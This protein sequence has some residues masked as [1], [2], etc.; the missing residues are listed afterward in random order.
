MNFPKVAVVTPGSF[1]IPSGRSSSVE[2]VIE[3]MMPYAAAGNLD[4]RI[5]GRTGEDGSLKAMIG[6]VPCLRVPGGA[7]Y[8]PSVLRHLRSW[9][10]DIIDVHNRPLLA[11]RLK[12]KLPQVQV[13]LSLHST[14]FIQGGNFPE[15][16]GR[17]LL[18]QLDGIIVNSGYLRQELFR[19]YPGL[20]VPVY[21]NHLGV[22]LE[23]FVPRWTPVGEALRKARLAEFGWQGRKVV[24]FLGRLI[25]EKGV[26][27]LLKTVPS[28]VREQPEALFLIVG[29]AYY[30]NAKETAYVRGLKELAEAYPDHVAFLPF[31]PYPQVADW[32]N[33]ADVVAVPSG[34][35][36][37][38]GLVNLEAMA[39]GVPVIASRTG[40]IPEI[41]EDGKTGLL[42]PPE[43]L[44]EAL[45]QRI[46]LLLEDEGKRRQM[47]QAGIETARRRFRWQHTAER[48][49]ALMEQ[50]AG[51]EISSAIL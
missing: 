7:A 35:E 40:G 25:P 11:C 10:P 33:I 39:T 31:T 23:D 34:E 36:E 6:P 3:K 17:H 50:Q 8:L 37:A 43:Q 4:I 14:A 26:H 5:Y 45:A 32:Y 28:V 29:S 48:W 27:T 41:I 2:R 22:S 13:C 44:E 9:R 19:R 47:G 49:A 38:F 16:G 30:N 12:Q 1:V 24:L 21:V 15:A 18:S 42:L 51:M 20:P 46:G